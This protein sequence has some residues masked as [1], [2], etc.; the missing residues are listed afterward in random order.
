MNKLLVIL[1]VFCLVSSV[2]LLSHHHV[3]DTIDDGRPQWTLD[4]FR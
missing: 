1:T 3:D 4:K 2:Y